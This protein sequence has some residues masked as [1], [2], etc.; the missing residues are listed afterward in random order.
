VKILI[1]DD[2]ETIVKTLKIS[3]SKYGEIF[4]AYNGEEALEVFSE[5]KPDIVLTD[6]FMPKLNGLELIERLKN[7]GEKSVF[8]ILSAF[9]ESDILRQAIKLGVDAY[10]L[11]PFSRTTLSSTLERLIEKVNREKELYIANQ[12]NSALL[13]FF[14]VTKTDKDGHITY[15]NENFCKISGYTLEELIGKN[16]NI[17]RHPDMDRSVFQD[18]WKTIKNKTVWQGVVKN[19]SK[20]GTTYV[21]QSSIFPI[22]DE[23]GEIVEFM[24][25]R[26]DITELERLKAQK[27]AQDKKARESEQERRTLEEINKAKDSFLILFTHELKTP[28]NSIINFTNYLI[29]KCSDDKHKELLKSIARNS[30]DTLNMVEN[31]LEL[32]KMKSGK[33]KLFPKPVS[34]SLLLK[35]IVDKHKCQ[36]Y[37][38]S[39]DITLKTDGESVVS[40]DKDRFAQAIEN[41]VNNAIKYG[42]GEILITLKTQNDSFSVSI[43]DNGE[44]I[45]DKERVFELFEQ[46]EDLSHKAVKGGGIGLH[47]VKILYDIL[48]LDITVSRSQELGGAKITLSQGV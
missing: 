37:G 19:L 42:G 43:E 48:G 26:E 34:L 9:E 27:E 11:K 13:N 12:H 5:V 38:N 22:L 45:K 7:S 23:S 40:I 39:F 29:G 8:A 21:A 46:G 32:A 17:T 15:A 3:L 33:I 14:I 35:E 20:N 1:V 31:I 18:L 41:L 2:E 24:A 4:C 47:T 16:H 44:G 6:I 28:L 25:I 10:I 36:K 30:T